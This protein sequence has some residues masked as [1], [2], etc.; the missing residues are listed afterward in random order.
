MLALLAVF[1]APILSWHDLASGPYP[2]LPEARHSVEM[3]RANRE[4]ALVIAITRDGK[5]YCGPDRLWLEELP[6]TI[7]ER[8]NAG[9][10]RK[11]YLKVDRWAKYGL[12]INVLNAVRSAG[13]ENIGFLAE[14]VRTTPRVVPP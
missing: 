1:I 8:L 14:N 10:E 7:R 13:V 2:D 4:D 3:P 11:A 12:V 9:A 5:V 6:A